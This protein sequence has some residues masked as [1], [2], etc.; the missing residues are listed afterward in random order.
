LKTEIVV[1]AMIIKFVNKKIE[2][3]SGFMKLITPGSI[4]TCGDFGN[5]KVIS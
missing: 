5:L 3:Y 4:V 1:V 2:M